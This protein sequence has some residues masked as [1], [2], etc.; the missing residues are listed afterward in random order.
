MEETDKIMKAQ[1]ARGADFESGSI[2][3]RAKSLIPLLVPL[4]IS[5]FRRANDL[6]MAMEARC[7]RGGEGRTKMKP[8]IY[9]K[10]D[11]AALLIVFGYVVCV[12]VFGRILFS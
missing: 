12:L 1:M 10:L 8:L 3:N 5:A 7:Y 4:F 11:I 9:K 2:M 6:A